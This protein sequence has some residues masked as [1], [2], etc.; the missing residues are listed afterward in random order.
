MEEGNGSSRG[1]YPRGPGGANAKGA[2]TPAL[3]TGREVADA[4]VSRGAGRVFA[5][6]TMGHPYRGLRVA[7]IRCL[8]DQASE[9]SEKE[10]AVV[11]TSGAISY[12]DLH[13]MVTSTARELRARGVAEGEP[14]A[15]W[16]PHDWRGPVLLL[17]VIRAGGVAVPLNPRLPPTA[18]AAAARQAGAT[19][20][21][22]ADPLPEVGTDA[23][24]WPADQVVVRTVD[25]AGDL[26]HLRFGLNRPVVTVFTSGS[27][28][29]PRPIRLSYG[30][31][32]YSARAANANLPLRSHDRWLLS[33]PLCHVGGLGILFRCLHAGAG[34]VV[35]GTGEGIEDLLAA[36]TVTHLSLVATQLRRLLARPDL[37]P[38]LGMLRVV[39]VGGG[40]V[41]DDLLD[42]AERR[43]L[44]VHLT[45][46][47]TEMASQVTTT[48]RAAT[49]AQRRTSG[50]ALRH[51][52]V[53]LAED[54]EIR[55]R[56]RALSADAPVD[57]AGWYATGDLGHW[58]SETGGLIVDGRKDSRMISGGENIQPE[59]I[60]AVLLGMPGVVEA[61]VAPVPD[62]EFGQRPVAFLRWEGDAASAEAVEAF[63]RTHLPGFKVPDAFLPWPED[64]AGL[65]PSRPDLRRR[66]EAWRRGGD[67]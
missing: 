4:L 53:E 9:I 54:G 44:P 38:R 36:E 18:A 31:L 32:Y 51:A 19:R 16:L 39:L 15:L 52:E 29:S 49:P 60:E 10:D 33:L 56:G 66:A 45:Y 61:V 59:E 7:D 6:R 25:Q 67:R 28:G 58:D 62:P 34:M 63:C 50:T 8:L 26:G 55:V 57:G 11:L 35:P 17:S 14:V 3:D 65:K 40:P 43:G 1:E 24:W 21:L 2:G 42:E 30:N 41:P 20:I 27:T 37:A 5:F 48:G 23:T 64:M 13:Y 12:R 46:G 22:A 47:L